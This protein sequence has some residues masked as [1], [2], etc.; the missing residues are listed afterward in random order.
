M[1]PLFAHSRS[2][3]DGKAENLGPLGPLF[4]HSRSTADGKAENLGPLFA[5]SRSTA[6]GKAENLGKFGVLT[7]ARLH[8]LS[9]RVLLCRQPTDGIGFA[10]SKL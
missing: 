5:H 10:V 9:P 2:T 6:D 1:G 4:A 8:R 7:V 3:A